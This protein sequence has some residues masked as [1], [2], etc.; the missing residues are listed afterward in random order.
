MAEIELP[1]IIT[2]IANSELE[3]FVAGTLYSQGWSV[4]YRAL[5]TSSLELFLESM[6]SQ[7]K[8]VL[9]IYSPDLPGISPESV[10]GYQEQVRQV[11]GFSADPTS[12]NNFS[13]IF[14]TPHDAT[15]LVSLIRGFVRAPLLRVPAA[16]TQ[17][18]R[19]ARVLSLGAASGST[20]CT[21][22]AI[23]LAMELSVQGHEVLLL[24][25]NVR[26]PSVAQLLAL[27][28]LD[29]DEP[30][31]TIAPHFCVGE[32]TKERVHRLNEYMDQ[33]VNDFD[34]VIVDLGSIE[35][36]ADS[37]TDRRWTATVIHWSCDIADELWFLGKADTLGIHRLEGLVRD[38][39]QIAIRAK[40]SV[41]L[42]MRPGGRKKGDHEGAFLSAISPLRPY[43]I[44]TLP[45]DSH[46][47]ARAQEERATLI[48]IDDRCALRKAISK[49]AVEV[50]S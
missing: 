29:G 9:L 4:I 37:L 10:I 36:I 32:L 25:G 11:I 35:D 12:K 40:V 49:I 31:R 46:V 16:A 22:V 27:R 8:S 24:D 17:T 21:T 43:R 14:A 41:L 26:H 39:S 18:K 48:E 42:N 3:G 19:R 45:K 44:F 28:K 47:V 30:W 7:V 15:E 1:V 13:G 6:A 34:V 23:N 33:A 5:D 20:G 50:M 38:F 2:A